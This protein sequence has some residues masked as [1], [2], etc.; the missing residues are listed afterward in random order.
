MHTEIAKRHGHATILAAGLF[1]SG[2]MLA[3]TPA[4]ARHAVALI[5]NGRVAATVAP[6]GTKITKFN[7]TI[8]GFNVPTGIVGEVEYDPDTCQEV[9]PGTWVINGKNP[10]HG[11]MGNTTGTG[12]LG[13][14]S[15]TFTY[16]VIEYTWTK[17]KKA[18]KDVF[19]A[20]WTTP[21]GQFN[22]PFRFILA[23]V[24]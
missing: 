3:A 2:L 13:G 15:G 18:T 14:C 24:Q 16:G 17:S 19:K 5:V 12:T 10:H 1:A 4:A 11:V 6:K 23:L 20:N 7:A 9:S 21:D 8:T 22:L